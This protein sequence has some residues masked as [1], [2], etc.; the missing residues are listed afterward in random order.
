MAKLMKINDLL[1]ITRAAGVNLREVPQ[2]EENLYVYA[3]TEGYVLYVGSAASAKRGRDEARF[4]AE[5]YED[6]LGIGF[7]ALITE[8]DGRRHSFHYDPADFTASTIL[9]QEVQWEGAAIE[10]VHERLKSGEAPTLLEVEELLVR[11]VV[12]TGRLIGNS[13]YASQWENTVNRFPN[14]LAVM[15]AYYTRGTDALP[16]R[17]AINTPV[18]ATPAS[19]AAEPVA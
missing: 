10:P 12:A 19:E 4:A 2:S 3:D 14:V 11:I 7:S 6:R 5:G 16:S 1:T 17:T 9:D 15:A 8:N 18:D 13:Q